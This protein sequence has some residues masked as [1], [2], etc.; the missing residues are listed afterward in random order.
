MAQR[1]EG[2]SDDAFEVFEGIHRAGV[3]LPVDDDRLRDRAE[4]ATRL[5]TAV[6]RDA[7]AGLQSARSR[8]GQE[9][10]WMIAGR[11]HVLLFVRVLESVEEVWVAVPDRDRDGESVPYRVRDVIFVAFEQAVGTAVWE[12]RFDWPTRKL[13]RYEMA[14]LYLREA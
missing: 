9:L 10:R 4:G 13:E 14:R 12:Q 2:S 8:P 7:P 1:E 5:A 11:I 3:L 6:Q